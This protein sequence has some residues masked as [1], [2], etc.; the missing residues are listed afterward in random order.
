MDLPAHLYQC[1][2]RQWSGW[3]I[4]TENYNNKDDEDNDNNHNNDD[5]KN[6]NTIIYIVYC[7]QSY[8]SHLY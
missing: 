7:Y 1:L 6:S 5:K 8:C 3:W 2:K 4:S